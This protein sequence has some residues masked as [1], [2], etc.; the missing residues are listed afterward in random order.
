M[1]G[2]ETSGA[3]SSNVRGATPMAFVR[4]FTIPWQ[5]PTATHIASEVSRKTIDIIPPPGS[6]RFRLLAGMPLESPF[7]DVIAVA[8]HFGLRLHPKSSA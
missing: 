3:D 5:P 4:Q 1:R 2:Y 8:L 6:S 7:H